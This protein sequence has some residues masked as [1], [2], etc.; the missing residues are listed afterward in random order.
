MS[1]TKKRN[2][3][4]RLCMAAMQAMVERMD[5]ENENNDQV[6]NI[7]SPRM[8][9]LKVAMVIL[10]T[11]KWDR[12]QVML[13]KKNGKWEL[14][15]D[16]IRCD[17]NEKQTLRRIMGKKSAELKFSHTTVIGKEVTRYY[18]LEDIVK[19]N[20][21]SWHSL[22]NIPKR[23]AKKIIKAIEVIMANMENNF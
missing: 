11:N 14:P 1:K 2:A 18:Y 21:E 22:H 16:F 20:G 10:A 13:T 12:F 9:H 5:A 19:K 8:F 17:E 15:G 4:A 7:F 23:T 3:R 6:R